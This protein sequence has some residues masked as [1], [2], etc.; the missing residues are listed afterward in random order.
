MYKKAP[1][2]VLG[3]VTV[4]AWGIIN[5]LAAMVYPMC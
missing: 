4:M 3:L 1:N 5:A 2:L